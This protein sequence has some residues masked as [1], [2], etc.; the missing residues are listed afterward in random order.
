MRTAGGAAS[1]DAGRIVEVESLEQ[2]GTPVGLE[3]V[4]RVFRQTKRSLDQA[5]PLISITTCATSS[6]R[7]ISHSQPRAST[8]ARACLPRLALICQLTEPRLRPEPRSLTPRSRFQPVGISSLMPRHASASVYSKLRLDNL[9][10]VLFEYEFEL[11][12]PTR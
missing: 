3:R 12:A 8:P 10:E 2:L 11:S 7:V 1:D 6:P 4:P 5:V 9:L